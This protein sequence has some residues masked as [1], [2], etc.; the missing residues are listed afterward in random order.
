M[1]L[2]WWIILL[3][4]ISCLCLILIGFFIY[5]LYKIKQ[6]TKEFKLK[7]EL[8]KYYVDKIKVEDLENPKQKPKDLDISVD[9]FIKD[10]LKKREI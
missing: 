4:V 6:T 8:L 9:D 10:V 2:S 3:I 1:I 7:T 5:R